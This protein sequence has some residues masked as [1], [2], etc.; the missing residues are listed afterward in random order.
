VQAY[1]FRVSA[2]APPAF[3]G[4]GRERQM[5]DRLLATVRR[6]ESAA[7]VIRGEAGIGKTALMDYCASQASGCRITRV[8][9][10]ETEMEMP[11]AALHQFCRQMSG[12]LAALPEPQKRALG[13]ALGVTDGHIPDRFV[14]GLAVLS[15]LA[16]VSAEH[17][18]VCLVDD[19]QWLDEPSAHVLGFAARRLVA[20]AVLFVF[21]V[22]EGSGARFLQGLPSLSLG[23]L[24]D[25]DA[26]A[27]LARSVRG[28][29]DQRVL[30]RIVAETRGNP[31]ALL[32][33]P[34]HMSHAELTGGFV[35]PSAENLSRRLLA[36]YSH[37]L[38]MLPE[39]TQ[40]LLV[41]AAA[42]PTGDATL[43]WRAARSLG[44]DQSAADAARAE[45]LLEIGPG[46]HF[47]HP[48]VRS[49]A[50]AAATSDDRRSAHEALAEATDAGVDPDRRVWHLAAAARGPDEQLA[51]ELDE[52]AGRVQARAGL[53]A[54]AAFLHR[55]L[56]LTAEPDRR[57]DRALAAAD[58]NMHAGLFDAALSLL[59]YAEAGAVNDL[60]RAR[61]Q[62]LRGK[63]E[64]AAS[65]GREAPARL[66]EA[67][68]RLVPLDLRLARETYLEAWGAAL[69]AGRLAEPEG[70]LLDVSR[71]ALSAPQP[72][73]VP[74]P[75][76]LLLDGLATMVVGGRASAAATL[77]RA[78]NAFLR[79]EV[80]TEDWLRWGVRATTAA[81]ALWDF[82]SWANVSTRLV[83]IARTYG[84]L[85]PLSVALNNHGVMQALRGNF[86]EVAHLVAEQDAVWEVTGTSMARYSAALLAA[87]RA[88]AADASSLISAMADD[89]IAD[90][91]GLAW[92]ISQWA[93]AVLHNGSARYGA[94]LD[95]A[96]QAVDEE[97]QGPFIA[98]FALPELVEAA[99]KHGETELARHAMARLSAS[100]TVDGADWA[101]GIEARSRALV[102]PGPVAE[103]HYAKA[104]ETLMRT[105]LRPELGRAHLLYGEWLRR[106]G[107]RTDARR[108]LRAAH[109]MFATMGAEAFAERARTELLATGEKVGKR[110]V[111]TQNELTPQE[112]H[113][114]RLARDGRTNP[115]IGAELFI[116][117]RTV[118]WHLRHVYAK[119]GITSRRDLRDSLPAR[120]RYTG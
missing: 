21:G 80:S 94:A 102:S 115:E 17:P 76:D 75:C 84:A 106:Q 27:L 4:R 38:Q 93:S 69:L 77:R 30:E 53:P 89:S 7:L 60:Q 15:L 119:L 6:G 37:S 104:I 29:L 34:R 85:A 47:R 25:E 14:V 33:L 39:E 114:A 46:V 55:S 61:V 99:A 35:V 83:E 11:F 120:S 23:G 36:H 56:E 64:S 18:L 112:E 111:A 31:L 49:A 98:A 67:A 82:D 109:D 97:V 103:E 79:D 92:Q 48:L 71:V 40:R 12:H 81:I 100:V 72:A 68:E 70:R 3:V 26:R 91:K 95:A 78:L 16:E 1:G 73:Q 45:Q 62:Q 19:A 105:E 96:R 9:G 63:V 59:A 2:I 51:R 8:T 41:V 44:V 13:I 54:A 117:A 74:R 22:R 101:T 20:E 66:L 42:D 107:R 110:E 50:Y 90:G 24:S 32:D 5:L 43:L 28:R 57:A 116:S 86:E 113:I 65:P 118:E 10:I 52:T 88:D 87:Y 108:Q 58:A